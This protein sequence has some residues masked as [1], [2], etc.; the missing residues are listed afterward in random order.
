MRVHAGIQGGLFVLGKG[1]GRHGDNGDAAGV[2]PV[3]GTN[4]PGGIVAVHHRH[5]HVHQDRV[6]LAFFRA[7]E[8]LQG[9]KAVFRDLTGGPLQLQELREDLCVYL[10]VLGGQEAHTVQS[11]ARLRALGLC[12]LQLLY[13]DAKCRGKE[14]LGKGVRAAQPQG[15][16]QALCVILSKK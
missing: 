14:G 16:L 8:A 1:V 9:Q 5:L 15:L 2:F 4:G 12:L 6:K 10:V 11:T 3:K 13:L 7:S